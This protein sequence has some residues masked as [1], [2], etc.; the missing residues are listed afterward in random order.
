M[1]NEIKKRKRGKGQKISLFFSI[2]SYVLAVVSAVFAIY[3]KM[4]NGTQS[5]IFASAL[6]SIFFCASCGFVLQFIANANLPDFNLSEK[7]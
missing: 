7:N 3:W 6:A 4:N 1:D 2:F 5:P